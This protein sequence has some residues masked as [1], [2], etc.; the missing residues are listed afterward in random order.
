MERERVTGIGGV[1]FKAKDPARLAAWYRDQLGFELESG[2][3]AVVVF[4]W[5]DGGSTAWSAFPDNTTY[6]GQPGSRAMINYRVANLDRML[7]QLRAGGVPVD[8]QV[9]DSEF[10]RFG[11]ATDPEGNRVELWEPVPGL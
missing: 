9:E 5:D 3:D 8:H 4:R 6:F 2:Q 7:E 10:G 1:F 11:W